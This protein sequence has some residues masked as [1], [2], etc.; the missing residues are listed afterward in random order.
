MATVDVYS[1]TKT[2]ELLAEKRVRTQEEITFTTDLDEV[3]IEKATVVDDASS[4]S[5]WVDRIVM[6]FKPSAILPSRMVHWL[7]EYFELRV[8][9][10]KHN[11][12]AFR[13][14][15]RD[16][17]TVQTT[18]RNMDVPLMEMMDDRVNRNPL[19]GLYPGAEIR[20]NEVPMNYAMVLG[21][22]DTIPAGTPA[23]TIIVRTT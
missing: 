9:P 1:Q 12:V 19:W 5:G 11:T 6:F 14:F 21:P 22:L 17:D 23:N 4:T 18:A 3:F 16:S 7:N 8:A 10:A 13:I 15:V 2:D 20:V